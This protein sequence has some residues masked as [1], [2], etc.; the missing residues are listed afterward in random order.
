MP[1]MSCYSDRMLTRI[2]RVETRCIMKHLAVALSEVYEIESAETET[3][4]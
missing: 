2:T 1:W 3:H 4:Q